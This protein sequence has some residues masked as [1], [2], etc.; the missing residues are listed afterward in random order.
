MASM[1]PS[2]LATTKLYVDDVKAA[3]DLKEFARRFGVK[4]RS[5][6]HTMTS[7]LVNGFKK[8]INCNHLKADKALL[9][10]FGASVMTARLS[11]VDE[12]A[13]IGDVKP[14]GLYR[15]KKKCAK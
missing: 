2:G 12:V 10:Y 3:K 11:F 4:A 8:D 5:R 15:Q 13:F 6:V 1:Q 9:H 14:V 7:I